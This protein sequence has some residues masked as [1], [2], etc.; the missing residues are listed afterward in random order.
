M[1]LILESCIKN[2]DGVIDISVFI[3]SKLLTAKAVSFKRNMRN[4]IQLIY[5]L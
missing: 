5:I 1:R 2:L 4:K 3:Q